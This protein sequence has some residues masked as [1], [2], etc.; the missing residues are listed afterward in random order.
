MRIAHI[1]DALQVGGKE[2]FVV[3]MCRLQRSTGHRPSVHCLDSVGPLGDTLRE[4]G[5]AVTLH[6]PAARAETMSRLAEALRAEAPDVAHCH[7]VKAT[8]FGAPVARWCGVPAV[9]STR[10]NLVSPPYDSKRELQYALA[11]RW[12]C[13]RTITVCESAKENLRRRLLAK[14]SK[15]STIY[16]GA[17]VRKGGEAESPSPV[18]S[19]FTFVQISRLTP[20]KDPDS[21]LCGFQKARQQM[22]ELRLWIVGDGTLAASARRLCTELELDPAVTFFGQRG[23]VPR[24]LEAADCF[25]LSSRSEGV[26]IAQLE[27]MAAGLPMI[28]SRVGG[29]PEVLPAGD[30]FLAVPPGDADAMAAAMVALARQAH[31]REEWAAAARRHYQ[32]RF[33]LQRMADD[34]MRLYESLQRRGS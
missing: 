7:N 8:V 18:K 32:Q 20:P 16:N 3:S 4:E 28:V 19:G 11:G 25:V 27:A 13:H 29:M 30:G 10:H 9:I 1:V 17:A 15:I 21:L 12:F 5:F 26:P 14:A 31:K 2:T 6:G 33:T 23:D 22:P 34:Y 24:F